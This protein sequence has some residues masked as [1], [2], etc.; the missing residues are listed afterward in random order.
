MINR[1]SGF[2]N[3]IETFVSFVLQDAKDQS[4]TRSLFSG[5]LIAGDQNVGWGCR[6]L[7]ASPDCVALVIH[8]RYRSCR[9]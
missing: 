6:I 8:Q 1:H 2:G 5:W 9:K 3:R 4:F 7:A